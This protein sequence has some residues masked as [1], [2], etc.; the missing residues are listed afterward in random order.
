M[1]K[2]IEKIKNDGVLKLIKPYLKDKKAFLIGGF[3]RDI[4]MDKD[5]H[6][7]D[8]II[9]EDELEIFAKDLA[10]KINAYFIELDA[11]NNIYRLVLEDK[12]NYIDIAKPIENDFEK[13]IKRR[14][15]TIN[16][17]A[18]DINKE[19]FIDIVG[20]IKDIKNKKIKGISPQNFEDDPLRLL[21][22]FRFYANTCFDL[23]KSL[24]KIVKENYKDINK[25]AKERITAEILKLFEGKYASDALLK[26]DECNLLEEIFPIYKEVKKIPSNS[27]HHLDLFHHLAETVKQLQTLYENS[28][29]EIKKYL[30]LEKGFGVKTIAFLKMAG[31]LHDIGK[32]SCW[33]IEEETGRHRFIKH[34]E[35]GSK[36]V[37]PI[38]KNLKFSKK[39]IEYI[40]KLIKFH[41]YP[42][43]MM[44]APDVTDKAYM[45]FYRKMDDCVIDVIFLAE[46]DR[47][48]AR[49]EKVT[50]EMV[51]RNISNLSWLL[52]N[53]L[54]MKDNI[55]P[56]DK[57]LDGT[58]IMEILG[59]SQGPEL[60]KIINALKEAQISGDVNTKQE[61]INFV[62]EFFNLSKLNT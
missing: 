16:A 7:R 22:I 10:D 42:S 5:S 25:P 2:Y 27:H 14:D 43:S 34:D 36:L 44:S 51:D 35:I 19:Q 52:S 23:D 13:D 20:G 1:D 46:A 8:L 38:L 30:D 28:E 11:V 57:F 4:L 55:K 61:A 41:I 49:G 26:M 37:V 31:F 18:Y 60:G 33:T 24:I 58:D 53:Y 56:I 40:K 62:K 12:I 3:V 45:K 21:R 32:P 59:I 17:I 29:E 39:Q 6:D 50:Q 47:L 15:L 48:S 54:K 9:I